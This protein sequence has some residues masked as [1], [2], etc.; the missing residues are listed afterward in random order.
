[1]EFSACQFHEGSALDNIKTHT[2]THLSFFNTYTCPL[3]EITNTSFNGHLSFNG[4]NFEKLN[5]KGSIIAGRLSCIMFE[6]KPANWE[7]AVI[8]KH[9][10]I[11]RNN[12]IEALRY[13]AIEKDLYAKELRAKKKSL[14]EWGEYLAL[15]MS[16]LSN[17]HGQD[18]LRAFFMTI[19]VFGLLPFTLFYLPVPYFSLEWFIMAWQ[20]F[21]STEFLS[22][23][24]E[25][26]NPT[27]YDLLTEA[28]LS[29]DTNTT[30]GLIKFF[31]A[32]TFSVGKIFIVYGGV[33]VVQAFRKYNKNPS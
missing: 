32:I 27:K 7:T 29:S 30:H 31:G 23:F 16:W 24:I 19:F 21:W 25:Y 33:E 13:K 12:V 10:E 6:P 4:D 5:L 2:D 14:Q 11:K 8:L 22:Y 28:Y 9:E 18:W 17:N 1:M 3:L 26:F 20:T 15:Q